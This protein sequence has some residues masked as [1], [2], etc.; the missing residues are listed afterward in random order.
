M[1]EMNTRFKLWVAVGEDVDVRDENSRTPLMYAVMG[2]QRDIISLLLCLGAEINAQDFQGWTALHHAGHKGYD[3]IGE[4]LI[5]VGQFQ[6][7]KFGMSHLCSGGC[8][9]YTLDN[10]YFTQTFEVSVQLRTF[11]LPSAL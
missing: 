2:T 10:V 7:S 8:L 9:K 4:D 3:V 11:W 5:R 1:M 6:T